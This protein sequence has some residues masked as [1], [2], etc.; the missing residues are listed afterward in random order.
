[1]KLSLS[2]RLLACCGMIRPGDV[3]ADI[4]CDHG[5]LGIYLLQCGIADSVIAADV[6]RQ[7]LESA[8]RNALKHGTIGNMR[9]F[10]SDGAQSIPRDFSVMVC[11]GM[12]ADTMI[13]ILEHAPWLKDAQYRI[14]LQCQSKTP[15]LRQYVSE[16][17][18]KIFREIP[19]RD[20]K[21]L[22]TVMELMYEPG[23][24]LTPGQ[25]YLSPALLAHPGK[26]LEDYKKRVLK[27]LL[28]AVHGRGE[29]AEPVQIQALEEL[30]KEESHDNGS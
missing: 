16:H 9:F 1:M 5:Y 8:R 10:L 14:V 22:Y 4:G 12:G 19:V 24:I 13:S 17:G 7:P 20:G 2:P 6:N 25:C 30:T 23:S 3:V 21:F 26:L 15:L 27:G 18:W 11:A 29:H 28:A